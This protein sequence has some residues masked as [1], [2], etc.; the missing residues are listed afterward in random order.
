MIF[1]FF[2]WNVGNAVITI[3]VLK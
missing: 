1:Y 2:S 3:H